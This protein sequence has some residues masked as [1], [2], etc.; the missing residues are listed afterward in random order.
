MAAVTRREKA[1]VFVSVRMVTGS[2]GVRWRVTRHTLSQSPKLDFVRMLHENDSRLWRQ[3][4][5]RPC[6]ERRE[7]RE[8]GNGD[9]EFSQSKAVVVVVVVVCPQLD[10]TNLSRRAVANVVDIND[11]QLRVD[12]TG[13][14]HARSA[15]NHGADVMRVRAVF[16]S[17]DPAP[18][19][20]RHTVV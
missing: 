2:S 14:N 6:W 17:R 11:A 18:G 13:C 3:R 9:G 5:H 4:V 12:A 8:K 15:H 20:A 16:A 19:L 1:R 7:L 10:W